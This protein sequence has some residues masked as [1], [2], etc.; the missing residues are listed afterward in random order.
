M[1]CDFCKKIWNSKEEYATQFTHPYDENVAIVLD[2]W[3]GDKPS[4]YVPIEDWFYSDTYLQI[5]YCPKCGRKLTR[6]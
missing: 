4:L 2:K 3:Y 6:D 5:D 1:A